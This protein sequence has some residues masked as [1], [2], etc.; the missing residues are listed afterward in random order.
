MMLNHHFHTGI[1]VVT[2]SKTEVSDQN[3]VLADIEMS[4]VGISI[5]KGKKWHLNISIHVNTSKSN[6]IQHVGCVI[7]TSRILIQ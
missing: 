7:I 5:V 6:K 2:L 4:D 1:V 3:S